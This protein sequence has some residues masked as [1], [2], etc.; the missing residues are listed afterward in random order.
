VDSPESCGCTACTWLSNIRRHGPRS[1]GPAMSLRLK[2]T[3]GER[4]G[5]RAFGAEERG[6]RPRRR[7]RRTDYHPLEGEGGQPLPTPCTARRSGGGGPG[8]GGAKPGSRART[9]NARRDPDEGSG[10]RCAACTC[11]RTGCARP[12]RFKRRRSESNRRS[13][14]CSPLPY[15]L[16]T[17]PGRVRNGASSRWRRDA[18]GPERNGEVPTPWAGPPRF[19]RAGNRTRTGDPHLGK[20]VLY[21]LSYSRVFLGPPECPPACL[22]DRFGDA[23]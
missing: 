2:L 17:A 8:A 14:I 11:V 13:R 19:G 22:A 1:R 21:Q 3:E 18:T 16:A 4:A 5:Y 6:I 7:V 20:V 10:G 15:H 9:H 23:P 12:R